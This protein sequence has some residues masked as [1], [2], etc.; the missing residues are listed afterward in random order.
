[1]VVGGVLFI[2]L[3]AF[4]MLFMPE[5]GFTPT[6]RKERNSWQQMI[7]TFSQGRRLRGRPVLIT[8]LVIGVIYGAFSEDDRCGPPTYGISP[9]RPWDLW[10][11]SRGS[12]C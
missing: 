4:L 1:V 2:G 9:C 11:Q 8:I 7:H 12:V 6:P 10:S 5:Q 3:G